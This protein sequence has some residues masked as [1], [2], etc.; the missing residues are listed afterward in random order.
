MSGRIFLNAQGNSCT[1]SEQSAL[2]SIPADKLFKHCLESGVSHIQPQ[3]NACFALKKLAIITLS[4]RIEAIVAER[5]Y[6]ASVNLAYSLVG[7]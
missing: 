3:K 4:Q 2:A 6:E 7:N 5:L 1:A